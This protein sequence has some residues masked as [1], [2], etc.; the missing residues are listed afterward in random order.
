MNEVISLIA[1]LI[2]WIIAWPLNWSDIY[3]I[4][5]IPAEHN[6]FHMAVAKCANCSKT[7]IGIMTLEQKTSVKE[8]TLYWAGD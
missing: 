5:N 4:L 3:S 8:P 7:H 2:N 6:I 1:N